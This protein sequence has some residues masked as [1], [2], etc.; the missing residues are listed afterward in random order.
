MAKDLFIFL[1]HKKGDA[2]RNA[3]QVAGQLALFGGPNV[4]V[5]C[6]ANF[7]RGEEWEPK[8]REGLAKAHWLVLLYT[9]PHTDWDWC[10]YETGYF[11]ALMDKEPD[12]RLICLH[13]P[14]FPVPAP[15]RGINHVPA[16]ES[17]VEKLF[18]DIYK[19][20]P[21]EL[22][23]EIFENNLD[24][25]KDAV[26]RVCQNCRFGS[27]P[28]DNRRITPLLNVRIKKKELPQLDQGAIPGSSPVTGEGRW[29]TLFGKPE[30]TAGWTWAELVTGVVD[31]AAWE[32]QLAMM[33]S[34]A[35]NQRSVQYPSIAVRIL[36]RGSEDTQN[37]YRIGLARV[38]EFEDDMEFVFIVTRI[39]TPFEPSDDG[40]ETMLY[41][42]FNMAW[43][44]RRRFIEY[45]R[46]KMEDLSEVQ[47]SM[48]NAGRENDFKKE[49]MRAVRDIRIDLSSVEADSQVRGFSRIVSMRRAFPAADRDRLDAYLNMEWPPLYTRLLDE[50]QKDEPKP[51][52]IREILDKMDPINKWFYQRSLAELA[53]RASE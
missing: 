18:E 45:H 2:E 3:R 20:K 37:V 15:L 8:I 10:L 32:Y 53:R 28:K 22:N 27:G 35:M 16:I 5:I 41:H 50:M 36:I 7:E 40:S 44:F 30:A 48:R 11:R 39:R 42:L 9:G 51:Q 1:S 21:W 6:S 33:M 23:P 38:S 31:I 29:E 19:R 24:A 26:K 34:E 4:K 49:V 14:N 47:S 52:T 12:R 25:V 46:L 13:D 43:H 17:A